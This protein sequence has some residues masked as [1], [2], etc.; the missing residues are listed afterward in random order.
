MH[1]GMPACVKAL[2]P[3]LAS[4]VRGASKDP[5]PVGCWEGQ[6]L[7][8]QGPSQATPGVG[9]GRGGKCNLPTY[10]TQVLQVLIAY[11][12]LVWPTVLTAAW[13]G[14][15]KWGWARREWPREA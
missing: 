1:R 15:H 8:C 5:A 2:L 10:E 7:L 6:L 11:Q 3:G 13:P 9:G 4:Q 14:R 12:A